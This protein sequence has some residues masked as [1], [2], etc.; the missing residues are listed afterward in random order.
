MGGYWIVQKTTGVKLMNGASDI[1]WQMIMGNSE[2]LNKS[3]WFQF[4]LVFITFL[5][6]T[7]IYCSPKKHDIIWVVVLFFV[8]LFL[9]YTEL[10]YRICK[11]FFGRE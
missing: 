4:D 3:M 7:V 10:N 5:L 8:A 1:A 9:Q 2:T 11:E 6:F